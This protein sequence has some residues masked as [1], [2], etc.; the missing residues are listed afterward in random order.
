MTSRK[1][2]YTGVTTPVNKIIISS[3]LKFWE[4]V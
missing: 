1:S 3:L 4:R 2:I